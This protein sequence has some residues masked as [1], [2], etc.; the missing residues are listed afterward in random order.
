[1]N[2]RYE[3]KRLRS[4]RLMSILMV[5]LLMPA[6]GVVAQ[7]NSLSK[8]GAD[9][10]YLKSTLPLLPLSDSADGEPD[11]VQMT[12]A[13]IQAGLDHWTW[14][15]PVPQPNN[16]YSV[17]LF[18]DTLNQDTTFG[19]V[20]EVGTF[21]R[22]SD[23]GSSWRFSPYAANTPQRLVAVAQ[24][25]IINLYAVGTNG[26]MVHSTDGGATWSFIDAHTTAPLTT[27]RFI[28]STHGWIAGGTGAVKRTFDTGAAWTSQILVPS[29]KP[30]D[31]DFVDTDYG[32]LVGSAGK[33]FLTTKGG[34]TWNAQGGGGTTP[35]VGGPFAH[36][37]IGYA[38]VESGSVLKTFDGGATWTARYAQ[39]LPLEALDIRD[40]LHVWV[41]GATGTLSRSTEIGRA[42]V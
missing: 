29:I 41:G 17:D 1:M 15:N 20:G 23:G 5:L 19:A 37:R 3:L 14:A 6:A 34:A 9:L 33:I 42:H 39:A 4:R 22:T 21:L 25:S 40:S 16:L 28:D 27:L 10:P 2:A 18:V 8:D 36:R 13:E 35:I 12:A 31:I 32:W 38:I 24:T 7:E 11:I 26:T 30:Y